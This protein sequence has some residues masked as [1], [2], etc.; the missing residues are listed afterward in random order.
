[1]FT[2][3]LIKK[4]DKE[5]LNRSSQV[6]IS[7]LIEEISLAKIDE[8]EEELSG[9]FNKTTTSKSSYFGLSKRRKMLSKFELELIDFEKKHTFQRLRL[10][11]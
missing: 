1:M 11:E 8:E 10:E 2:T 5:L 6:N 7:R 3:D 4:E 9:I